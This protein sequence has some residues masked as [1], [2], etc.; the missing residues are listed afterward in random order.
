MIKFSMPKEAANLSE[1]TSKMM[2]IVSLSSA[3]LVP[4]SIKSVTSESTKSLASDSSSEVEI[5]VSSSSAI[6][7]SSM[8]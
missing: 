4:S 2:S 1:S 3:L 8:T 7:F 6:A 5:E